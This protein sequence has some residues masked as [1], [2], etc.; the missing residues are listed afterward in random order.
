MSQFQTPSIAKYHSKQPQQQT[1]FSSSMP[2]SGSMS[3]VTMLREMMGRFEET[4]NQK[5][6]AL[7][8]ENQKLQQLQQPQQEVKYEV[9]EKINSDFPQVR[10][11]IVTI[12]LPRD[13]SLADLAAASE[14]QLADAKVAADKAG[15]EELLHH[16]ENNITHQTFSFTITGAKTGPKKDSGVMDLFEI[17]D[18]NGALSDQKCKKTIIAAKVIDLRNG[19]KCDMNFTFGLPGKGITT[20]DGISRCHI[21]ALAESSCQNLNRQVIEPA[22]PL[23]EVAP[24]KYQCFN[25]A[26]RMEHLNAGFVS[27]ISTKQETHYDLAP[28]SME[29]KQL[30]TPATAN[31]IANALGMS[32]DD[33]F[34]P[35]AD[36]A[37]EGGYKYAAP[38]KVVAA[39]H[40]RFHNKFFKSMPLHDG[41]K[42]EVVMSR[43]GTEAFNCM[44]KLCVAA[45]SLDELED[46]KNE[47]LL[48]PS[49]F[50]IT[51]AVTWAP[52][53]AIYQTHEYVMNHF[54]E[55]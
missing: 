32:T 47:T 40:T 36:Q 49:N 8:L 13:M 3:E 21:T 20:T 48:I 55:N 37:Y 51:L 41:D 38:E 50:T 53:Y 10:T 28:D 17:K 11:E 9:S 52:Q 2:S 16:L 7:E 4:M 12:T 42:L 45:S 29:M 22:E 19:Y 39:V 18:R 46:A 27:K 25:V 35:L 31:Y 43:T 54:P 44:D 34:K 26:E 33:L 6:R 15:N 14:D 5:M 23:R 1:S 24:M 30:T